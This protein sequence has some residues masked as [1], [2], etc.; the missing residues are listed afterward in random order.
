MKV[1]H[2]RGQNAARQRAVLLALLPIGFLL[3][4]GCGAKEPM[5]AEELEATLSLSSPAFQDGGKIPAKHTCEG[6]DTSPA[7]VWGEPP[8][9]TQSFVLIMDDPD[10]P[11]GTFT[12][13]VIF[14]IPPDTR[15]LAGAI[16]TQEKL[17]DGALQ[18]KNG[19]GRIGYGGPCPPPGGP[20]HY[21]FKLYALD[22]NLDLKTGAS[23][24]QVIDAMQGRILTW[25]QLTGT[26]QR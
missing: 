11:L 21:Q 4:T 13:W 15:Q 19:F 2:L 16:P 3:L 18:G 17:P 12:H 25:G 20:H 1:K 10:A 8:A 6:D 26:Y 22:R 7:L 23:K 9:G 24:K 5:P 14:N